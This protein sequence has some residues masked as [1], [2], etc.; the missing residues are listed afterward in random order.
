MI[1][2]ALVFVIWKLSPN[3][4]LAI[5]LKT[6]V[7]FLLIHIYD[8]ALKSI[9]GLL[10]KLSDIVYRQ[11]IFTFF[12]FHCFNLP[13]PHK[14]VWMF[15]AFHALSTIADST[16]FMIWKIKWNVKRFD[17]Q[18]NFFRLNN[19]FIEWIIYMSM[20]KE[21]NK[22][23]VNHNSASIKYKFVQIYFNLTFLAFAM[24]RCNSVIF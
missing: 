18:K 4:S 15:L 10:I 7:S 21:R 20:G 13:Y 14:N 22:R 11:N 24:W 1:C 2:S 6:F 9:I 3:I 16:I 8:M 5:H 12:K 17:L 23:N 19:I